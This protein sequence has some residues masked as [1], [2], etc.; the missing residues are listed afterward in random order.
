M[1]NRLQRTDFATGPPTLLHI[2]HRLIIMIL[3]CATSCACIWVMDYNDIMLC[4][5]NGGTLTTP[6]GVGLLQQRWC[7]VEHHKFIKIR[8]HSRMQSIIGITSDKN[9][10]ELYTLLRSIN[11][12]V[13]EF[14]YQKIHEEIPENLS[15]IL[16]HL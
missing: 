14:D 4:V 8:N 15:R 6:S 11:S 12:D 7:S 2:T 5:H 13:R 9:T 16:K 1:R 3:I 10:H